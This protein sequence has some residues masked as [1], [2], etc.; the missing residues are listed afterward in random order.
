MSKED[1]LVLK[2]EVETCTRCDL[3]K[4]RTNVVFGEGSANARIMLCG[5]APGYWEDQKGRPFVGNAGKFLDEL[6]SIAGLKREEVFIANILKCRPPGNREPRPEEIELCTSF[7]NKQIKIIKPRII[8]TL[9]NYATSYILEKYGFKSD[10]MGK[11]HGKVFRVSNLSTQ[12]K[13]IPMYHPA[14]A[15]YKP[16]MKEVIKRDWKL[17]KE[18][19]K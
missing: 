4:T 2:K 10:S 13:I 5:E 15:L 17:I 18:E 3:H 6:L 11:I 9:G 1:L 14:T 8:C 16:Y 7:L 12:L 19:L